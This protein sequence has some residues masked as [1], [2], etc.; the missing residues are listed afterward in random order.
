MAPAYEL[1]AGQIFLNYNDTK[2]KTFLNIQQ[3]TEYEII[4]RN[5]KGLIITSALRL[6]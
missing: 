2:N 3:Q 1:E 4:M 5:Q 6:L